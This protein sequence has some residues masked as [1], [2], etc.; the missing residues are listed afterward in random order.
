MDSDGESMPFL[1]LRPELL[2]QGR[3]EV[4]I[5]HSEFLCSK[6]FIKHVAHTTPLNSHHNKAKGFYWLQVKENKWLTDV[7]YAHGQTSCKQHENLNPD[8]TMRPRSFWS[9]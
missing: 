1:Q 3:R 6:P 2:S 5:S 8:L 9:F 4:T 7:N